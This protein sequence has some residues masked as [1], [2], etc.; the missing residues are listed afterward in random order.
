MT[1]QSY[2][3]LIVK[4]L[5]ELPEQ[6]LA[7]IA[8]FVY[9]VRLRALG[10]E[11]ERSLYETLLNLERERLGTEMESHLEEEFADYEHLYPKE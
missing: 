11:S 2:Q 6:T 1:V 8:D 3:Q 9:F 5:Q 10:N 4:G 7:E